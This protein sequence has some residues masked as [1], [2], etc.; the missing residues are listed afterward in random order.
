[1]KFGD[2][3]HKC[4]YCKFFYF[5]GQECRR[6]PPQLVTHKGSPISTQA[7]PYTNSENWCG[8]FQP[9]EEK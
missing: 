1:M 6:H 2:S 4:N 8:E 3:D 5:N 7:F 9:K